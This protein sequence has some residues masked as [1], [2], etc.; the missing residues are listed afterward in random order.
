MTFKQHKVL[1]FARKI[2]S[3]IVK[4]TEKEM[5]NPTETGYYFISNICPQNKLKIKI[6]FTNLAISTVTKKLVKK[7]GGAQ[8]AAILKELFQTIQSL[9]DEH[10]A[11]FSLY[12]PTAYLSHKVREEFDED[13]NSSDLPVTSTNYEKITPAEHII[14]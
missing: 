9:T 3:S 11:L 2:D 12:I 7:F 13:T 10:I 5:L 4:K 1:L 14:G 6:H 8:S